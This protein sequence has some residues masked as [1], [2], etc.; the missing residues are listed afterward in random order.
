MKKT[1]LWLHAQLKMT[2]HWQP[3]QTN[4]T[5]L[6]QNSLMKMTIQW[7]HTQMKMTLVKWQNAQMK[8]AYY[9]RMHISKW[10]YY[11]SMHIW[12]WPHFDCTHDRIV[13]VFQKL[14][15]KFLEEDANAERRSSCDLCINYRLAIARSLTWNL[16]LVKMDILGKP[17]M[18]DKVSIRYRFHILDHECSTKSRVTTHQ[19]TFTVMSKTVNPALTTRRNNLGARFAKDSLS[20]ITMN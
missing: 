10:P 13:A 19:N 1:V 6:W 8:R 7:L 11:D 16:V 4:M 20:N 2:V 15:A 3:A 5:R 18:V 14:N 12:K 9:D 17:L